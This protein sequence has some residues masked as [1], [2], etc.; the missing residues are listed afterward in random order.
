VAQLSARPVTRVILRDPRASDQDF[1]RLA[2]HLGLHGV[3]YFVGFSAWLDIAPDGANKASA[4]AEVAAELGVR[5]SDVLAL[6]DGR[7]DVEMLRWAGR[8]VAM[9][10][11]PREVQQAADHVTGRFVD[12]GTI[13][14][15]DRWF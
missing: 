10:D 1:I 11:A 9:G 12:G 15:L 2:E 8:G 5:R 4:L 14:E 7:N 3:S 13:Q 6:G